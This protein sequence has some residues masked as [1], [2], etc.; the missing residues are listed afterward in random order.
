MCIRDSIN[1][2]V[3][4][5]LIG[6]IVFP[7][8]TKN[9]QLYAIDEALCQSNLGAAQKCAEE[10][11]T[12]LKG[13]LKF[14]STERARLLFYNCASLNVIRLQHVLTCALFV[15]GL[16]NNILPVKARAVLSTVSRPVVFAFWC[17]LL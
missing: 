4:V 8:Q 11:D 14:I 17:F 1:V 5:D 13:E 12:R 15:T 10:Y 3:A 7:I 9:K 6:V 16:S 2:I